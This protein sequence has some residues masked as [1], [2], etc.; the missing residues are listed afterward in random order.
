[1]N[2]LRHY[3]RLAVRPNAIVL[4]T[5]LV[6]L[7]QMA[8]AGLLLNIAGIALVTALAY[9]VIEPVFGLLNAR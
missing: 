8:R 1:M 2:R 6:R 7:P 4:G 3:R 5:D 9:L